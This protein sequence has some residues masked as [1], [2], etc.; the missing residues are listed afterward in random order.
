MHHIRA[1]VKRRPL[2]T[3][4]ALAFVL[5][6]ASTLLATGA[7]QLLPLLLSVVPALAAF[8][9]A[10]VAE[11]RTG[12]RALL[13]RCVIWRVSLT[14]Y[15]VVLAIPLLGTLAMVGLATQLGAPAATQLGHLSLILIIF[16][17][18]FNAVE[19]V[20]WRGFAVPHLLRD[21]SALAAGLI[22]GVPWAAFHLP[23]HLPGQWNAAAPIAATPLILIAYSVALTWVFIHTRGSVLLTTLCHGTLNALT[24]LTA[25]IA[26]AQAWWLRAAVFGVIA[27]LVVVATGPDLG[28]K[29]AVQRTGPDPVT[30]SP[31]LTPS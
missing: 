22:V 13:H 4:F 6:G 29:L 30:D 24:P 7:P 5:L 11:G 10:A 12:I 31:F 27:L 15:G 25:G 2:A 9:V 8:L 26:P 20:A 1:V 14:W 3:F 18:I 21:R 23:L 17:Y 28:R 19:E 16:A